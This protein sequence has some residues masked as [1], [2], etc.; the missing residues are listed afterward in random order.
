L[1]TVSKPGF[2]GNASIASELWPLTNARKNN[3]SL[4][5]EAVIGEPVS[6]SV[7]PVSRENT[8]NVCRLRPMRAMQTFHSRTNSERSFRIP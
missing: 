5:V 8:G 6:A 1:Q 2:A 4:A 7:F 3:K